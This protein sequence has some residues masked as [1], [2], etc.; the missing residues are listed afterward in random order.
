MNAVAR[1]ILRE[2]EATPMKGMSRH[3][4]EKQCA[5]AGLDPDRLDANA[6]KVLADRFERILP[7]FIGRDAPSVL[8]T[9][10]TLNEENNP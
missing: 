1:R 8:A 2:L 7:Y 9:I 6:I 5:D 10:R 3:F 4:L